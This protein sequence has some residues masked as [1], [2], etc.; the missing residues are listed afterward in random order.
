MVNPL[1]LSIGHETVQESKLR[2]ELMCAL[3]VRFDPQS[4]K[5]MALLGESFDANN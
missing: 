5:F 4:D 2:R 1:S 3:G